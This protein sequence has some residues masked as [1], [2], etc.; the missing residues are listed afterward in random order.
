GGHFTIRK[1]GSIEAR[2]VKC[3]LVEPEADR[4]FRFHRSVPGLP[5]T[6]A[7]STVPRPNHCENITLRRACPSLCS[8]DRTRSSLA[9]CRWN[10]HHEHHARGRNRTNAGN[11]SSPRYWRAAQLNLVDALRFESTQTAVSCEDGVSE[12]CAQGRR[13]PTS[14]S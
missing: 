5:V 3:V 7:S 2:R 4:V 9:L 11:W 1:G 12:V 14:W 13:A 10:W 6:E 8:R